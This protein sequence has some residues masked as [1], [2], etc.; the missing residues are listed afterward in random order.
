MPQREGLLAVVSGPAGSGKTT[1]IDKLLAGPRAAEYRR[2]VTATTRVPRPGEVHGKDYYFYDRT[3][4]EQ[5]AEQ[6]EFIE[7]TTFNGNYYGSPKRETQADLDRGG[8]VFLNIEVEGARAVKKIFT[9]AA[10]FFIVPPTPECLRQRLAGR[11]TETA[12]DVER[13]LKIA[14]TEMQCMGEYDFLII[15]DDADQA[16]QDLEDA[17]TAARRSLMF[18]NELQQWLDGA[19]AGWANR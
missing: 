12:A 13:R 9:N 6:G 16:A 11:G 19:F 7:Y 8:V 5:L 4:F 1:L 14:R 10:F 15:N 18:G 17:V 2:A 3:A